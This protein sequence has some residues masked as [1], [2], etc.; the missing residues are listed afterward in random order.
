MQIFSTALE[1]Q[2]TARVRRE[3]RQY[4]LIYGAVSGAAFALALWGW[5]GYLLYR[6]HALYPWMKLA[7]GLAAYL[8]LGGCAGALAARYEQ[9]GL[10]FLFWLLASLPLAWLTI[11]LPLQIV[12]RLITFLRP[13]FQGLVQSVLSEGLETRFIIAFVWAAIFLGIVG[14]LQLTLTESA[15]FSAA[16]L[17]KVLPLLVCLILAGIHG[18]I[19]DSLAN[20]PLRSAMLAM[21][22]TLTFHLEHQGQKVDPALA[23]QMHLGALGPVQEL[24]ERP[25]SLI[26]ARSDPG[27][28]EIEIIVQFPRGQARCTVLYN[29]PSFCQPLNRP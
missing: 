17:G 6:A 15:V 9:G 8:L 20:E 13:A 19:V 11:A 26:V 10:S 25:W 1:D 14:L 7:L 22:N 28:G 4:G 5:D 2:R 24:V 21:E 16:L 3:K 27:L 29:Q 12:P 18:T 23:R